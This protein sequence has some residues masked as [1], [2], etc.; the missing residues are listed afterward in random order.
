M[1][2][3]QMSINKMNIKML[4]QSHNGKPYSNEEEEINTVLQHG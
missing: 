2:M 3:T 4:I 1:E